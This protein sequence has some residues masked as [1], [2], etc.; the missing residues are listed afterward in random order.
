MQTTW[1]IQG[2][3]RRKCE[4]KSRR[5]TAHEGQH[6]HCNR[7]WMA[8]TAWKDPS[9]GPSHRVYRRLVLRSGPR[10]LYLRSSAKSNSK[11]PC[12]NRGH[13]S[14]SPRCNRV[15]GARGD[16]QGVAHLRVYRRPWTIFFNFYRASLKWLSL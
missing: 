1:T 7:W 16:V 6:C 12:R 4:S 5:K 10:N 11:D 3:P 15:L 9:A 2:N 8:I 13:P 14:R